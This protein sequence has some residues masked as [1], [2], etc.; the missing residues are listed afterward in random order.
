MKILA[1]RSQLIGDQIC[2]LPIASYFKR[3]YPNAEIIWPIAKK[4][5]QAAPLYMSHPDIDRIFIFDGQEAPESKRDLDFIKSCD[6]V[7]NPNPPYHPDGNLWPN[8][9][10]IYEETWIM[11]GLSSE[12]YKSL[13]DDQKLPK[14]NKWF[15]LPKKIF[16]EKTIGIWAQANYAVGDASKRNPSKEYWIQLINKLILDGYK[17]L[18]FGSERDWE[19]IPDS[20]SFK[21]L[22]DLSFFEQIKHCLNTNLSIGTDSGSSL[23]LAAYEHS[24]I[25]LLRTYQEDGHYENPFALGPLNKNNFSL[26]SLTGR[27][28][29][30]DQSLIIS[31]IYEY[32]KRI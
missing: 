28:D 17:I 12:T 19:L 16:D 25:T 3:L 32:T 15:N 7:I 8:L 26:A 29:S 5:S 13:S 11:A 9:R 27:H 23:I 6:L 24:Q 10:N 4:V 20:S 31:K 2:A 1:G 18:Q 22:N 21:R 14:L 30:I